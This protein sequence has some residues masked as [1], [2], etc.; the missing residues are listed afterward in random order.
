MT[1]RCAATDMSNPQVARIDEADEFRSLVIEQRISA[2]GVRRR[3]PD[4]GET[5]RNVTLQLVSCARVTA[6]TVGATEVH[7]RLVMH[8]AAIA[9]AL[10]APP[11]F[12]LSLLLRLQ[13][14][15]ASRETSFFDLRCADDLE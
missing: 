15:G 1:T 11:A 6:V 9:M 7:R 8:V 5:A 13:H 4:F 14:Q 10:H 2:D 3:G 12:H